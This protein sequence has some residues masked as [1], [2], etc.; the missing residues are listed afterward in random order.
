[1]PKIR[2]NRAAN[3]RFKRTAS[4]G[5]KR[6]RAFGRHL[7][8]VKNAKRTRSLRTLVMVDARDVPRI[9]KLL[10]YA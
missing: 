8:S 3:K 5:F 9:K 6:S 4:G 1:M 10:P 2:T 7:K